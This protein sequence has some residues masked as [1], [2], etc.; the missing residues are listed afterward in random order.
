MASK[1]KITQ[2]V[3]VGAVKQQIDFL[4]KSLDGVIVQ[5]DTLAGKIN[6]SNEA[7][8]GM[9][10]VSGLNDALKNNAK[11]TQ[12]ANQAAKKYN[13]EQKKLAAAQEQLTHL[14]NGGAS[15]FKELAV[16]T[17]K[18][19]QE[20]KKLTDEAKLEIEAQRA[21]LD[22][23]KAQIKSIEALRAE[24]SKLLKLRNSMDVDK[25][26]A[27][28]EKINKT[29]DKNTEVIRKNSDAA[30]KQKMNIGNY[31]GA[32]EGLPGPLGRAASGIAKVGKQ[33]W[34]LVM[35]P[36][37][38]IVAAIVLAFMAL[39]KILKSTDEG[40][41][42][43]D[44][45]M[46]SLSAIMDVVKRRVL[47]LVDAIKA[48]FSG[49]FREAGEKFK[50]SV[51]GIGAEM[52]AAAEMAFDLAYALDALNDRIIGNISK[53]AELRRE[54]ERQLNI[55]KDQALTDQQRIDALAK[56]V[57]LEK[58]LANDKK[59]YAEEGYDLAVREAALK[60]GSNEDDIK[61]LI[62]LDGKQAEQARKIDKYKDIWN[63]IG[64]EGIKALEESYK[65]AVEADTE[66]FR[67]TKRAVSQLSSLQEQQRRE[68]ETNQ[69]NAIKTERDINKMHQDSTIALMQNGF[70]KELLALQYSY[71]A[72]LDEIDDR[73]K[74]EANLTKAQQVKLREV[75]SNIL[76]QQATEEEA[77]ITA[78][79]L[80][81]LKLQEQ[82]LQ[83]RLQSEEAGSAEFITLR[84][85]LVESQRQV[86]LIESEKTGASK[87]DINAKYDKI[88]S[89]QTI[90]DT[91]A[92][93]EKQT[94]EILFGSE[95]QKLAEIEALRD[96]L[97]YGQITTE[98]YERDIADIEKKYSTQSIA[99]AIDEAAKKLEILR[100]LG[101]D[102]AEAER[103]LFELKKQLSDQ[104][105][106]NFITNER[107]KADE[108]ERLNE[109]MKQAALEFASSA[110]SIANSTFEAKKIRLDDE[111]VQD[112]EA[113]ERELSAAA[114][115]AGMIDQINQKYA[116]KEKAR[117]D[118]RR[119]IELEQ[120]KFQKA[121]TLV[122]AIINTALAITKV[123]PI[124][125]LMA[126]AASVGAM[127]V[128]AIAAQP[129]PKY[130]TGRD[131]GKA[132][133]AVVGER[134]SEVIE[135][136]GGERYITPSRPTIT[137]LPESA[138]VIPNHELFKGMAAMTM[139]KVDNF[140]GGQSIDIS[141]LK[142]EIARLQNGFN[143]VAATIRDKKE[144]HLNI[145][146]KGF[147]AVARRGAAFTQYL[148][149]NVR[150]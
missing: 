13:D 58:E 66:Y 1:G 75:K 12:E 10:T 123:S 74:D 25:Q 31:Q 38:A 111:A 106:A 42:F 51:S 134:G 73:L 30:T 142:A 64:D 77:M 45:V 135:T 145:T 54:I 28:I 131:G 146:E 9:K 26:K 97:K 122:Q 4:T 138:K 141:E 79:E 57:E 103:Q 36:I 48:L 62:S 21:K 102:T 80:N 70:E 2:I 50:A 69:K 133:W 76:R 148:D 143:M 5:F 96:K 11:V 88:I 56:A 144:L 136:A 22:S 29:I 107:K 112:Q 7:L 43:L 23:D 101:A 124:V 128:A 150:L 116:A 35:N 37:V 32:F 147:Q 52:A 92:T 137:F 8:K 39:Y 49:N 19:K 90:E 125:P 20:K 89:D 121:A 100:S 109:A 27:E 110:I 86:E 41:T 18:V 65:K 94:A 82:G 84:T 72:R 81:R 126:L 113:K 120:A 87:A 44:G 63:I 47:V 16:A 61:Y 127:Q 129:L 108:H 83:L 71:K 91:K 34:A 40:A 68:R 14:Q 132:E 24:N 114:G 78:N 99:L 98:Q 59:M 55:S 93:I 60:A 85:K 33:L 119:R 149:Q 67:S 130:A 15:A 3:D 104:E 6:T 118:E 46:K 140:T 105:A 139:T 95:K 17:E 117:E 53:E 115:N